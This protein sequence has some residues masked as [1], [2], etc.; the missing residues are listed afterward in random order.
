MRRIEEADFS[1]RYSLLVTFYSLL[2]AFLLVTRCFLLV[3][4][5]FLLVTHFFSLLIAFLLENVFNQI[6]TV[7]FEYWPFLE[8]VWELCVNTCDLNVRP[9]H[10]KIS[11]GFRYCIVSNYSISSMVWI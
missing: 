2:V 1:I 5:Y 6:R 7:I 4:R 11:S 10:T 3:T 9:F 8:R